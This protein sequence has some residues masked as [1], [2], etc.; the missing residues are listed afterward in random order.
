MYIS[1]HTLSHFFAYFPVHTTACS[2]LI[3]RVLSLPLVSFSLSMLRPLPL[4]LP[5]ILSFSPDRSLFSPIFHLLII[6]MIINLLNDLN[7][8]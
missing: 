3:T 1:D 7:V 2:L 8:T 5:S 4:N 6:T